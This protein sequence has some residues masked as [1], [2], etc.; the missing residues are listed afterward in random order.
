MS[1]V[2]QNIEVIARARSQVETRHIHGRGKTGC[3]VRLV[4]IE[5]IVHGFDATRSRSAHQ[6]VT[7]FQRAVLDDELGDHAAS[8]VLLGFQAGAISAALRIG[9]VVMQ[10]SNRQQGFEQLIDALSRQ[11]TAAD[12]FGIAAPLGRLQAGGDQLRVDAIKIDAGQIDL[13]QG[14]DDRHASGS[15]MAQSFFRLRHYTVV[16]RH[17]QYGNIGHVSAASSHFSKGLM[18]RRVDE[19]N[20]AAVLI[21]AIRA[22][23]LCD[24]AALATGD[25]D[26]DDLVQQRRFAVVDVP[27][28]S[29]DGGTR[30]QQRGIVFLFLDVAQQL[31]VPGRQAFADPPR[32]QTPETAIQPVRHRVLN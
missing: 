19:G 4:W 21:D 23:V 10:L 13:V 22:N 18:A 32:R 6:H 27:Q 9:S 26:A 7:D 16:G 29:D 3:F 25:V 1:N 5:R 12:Q 20:R 28:E 17:H 24:T 2:V 30:L 14:H 31:F 8:L 15:G 11:S